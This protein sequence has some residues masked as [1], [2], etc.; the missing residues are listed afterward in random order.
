MFA[1]GY[2]C[3]WNIDAVRINK[4]IPLKFYTIA[5]ITTLGFSYRGAKLWNG[6]SAESKQATSLYSFKK[7]I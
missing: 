6:L 7:T 1:S 5:K 2:F 4:I 3:D